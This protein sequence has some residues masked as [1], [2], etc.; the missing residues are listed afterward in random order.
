MKE[1]QIKRVL[2]E[3]STYNNY[4]TTYR[5]PDPKL[6]K[7]I[8]SFKL[9]DNK[10]TLG[11][12]EKEWTIV[13]YEKDEVKCQSGRNTNY[14]PI[15]EVKEALERNLNYKRN[16]KYQ[17]HKYFKEHF[18]IISKV[19]K[20]KK[21]LYIQVLDMTDAATIGGFVG[22][23]KS[24]DPTGVEFYGYFYDVN[25]EW[26]DDSIKFNVSK[27]AS[28]MNIWFNEDGDYVNRDYNQNLN[29]FKNEGADLKSV[30][31]HWRKNLIKVYGK[32]IEHLNG[33]YFINDQCLVPYVYDNGDRS[34]EFGIEI[35]KS[36]DK[37]KTY[38]KWRS[39]SIK[40]PKKTEWV[41]GD[42]LWNKLM[43]MMPKQFRN[44]L[45]GIEIEA[46]GV[47]LSLYCDDNNS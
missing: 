19:Y 39:L 45:E 20:D 13:E 35:Y 11:W 25:L 31:E 17:P 16:Q 1:Y 38:K 5:N 47:E 8:A 28:S 15:D 7:E 40:K 29:E 37:G 42:H 43:E 4:Y 32:E 41:N 21:S 14:F 10:V 30:L 24:L 46:D 9:P 27:H 36:E 33:K 22:I 34:P 6:R 44:V 18:G 23:D 26:Y 2:P 3:G 12:P